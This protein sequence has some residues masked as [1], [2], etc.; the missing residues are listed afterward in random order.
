MTTPP[1]RAAVPSACISSANVHRLPPSVFTCANAT[2]TACGAATANATCAKVVG[3][4]WCTPASGKDACLN[5]AEASK[6]AP[7]TCTGPY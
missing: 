6:E 5:F 1:A 2:E 4:S 3:C 7:G